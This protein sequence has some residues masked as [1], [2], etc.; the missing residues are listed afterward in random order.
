MRSVRGPVVL[1]I[2]SV[3]AA[4]VAARVGLDDR[5]LWFYD[6]PKSA[7]PTAVFWHEHAS[8]LALPLWIDRLGMGFPVYAEGQ[9][10]SFYLPNLLLYQFGPLTATDISRVLHLAFAGIGAGLIARR[11]TSDW[12]AAVVAAIGAVLAGGIVGKLEWTNVVVAYAWAPWVMLPLMRRPGPSRLGLVGAGT[13]WGIAGLA[14]HPDTWILIGITAAVL[15]LST[16][17]RLSTLPRIIGF[18]LLSVAVASVQLIPTL[19]LWSLSVRTGGLTSWDLFSNSATPLDLLLPGF[20]NAF[21]QSGP[22]GWDLG[23]Q[24]YPGGVWGLHEAGAYLGLPML[25][26]VGLG[27]V[28]RRSRPLLVVAVVM[29]GIA[30][31]G[32]FHPSVWVDTPILNG[33][34]HPTRSY[35]IAG[36]VCSILAGVGVSRVGRAAMSLRPAVV[37]VVGSI[38]L[39]LLV[40]YVSLA[41]P[42]L[43]GQL[44]GWA[45]GTPADSVASL[46]EAAVR[47]LTRLDPLVVELGTGV[48]ALVLLWIAAGRSRLRGR[49]KLGLSQVR[50]ALVVLAA[51]PLLAFSPGVNLDLT[52]DQISQADQPYMQT[53][54]RFTPKRVVAFI[55]PSWYEGIPNQLASAGISELSMWSSL[56]LERT[57]ALVNDIRYPQPDPT[58][59]RAAGVDVMATFGGAPCP[60]SNT[61]ELHNDGASVCRLESAP[62]PP[63]WLPA[64]AV[65]DASDGAAPFGGR[66]IMALMGGAPIDRS[67]DP[68]RAVSEARSVTVASWDETG[69]ELLVDA[70]DA[71]WLYIDRAWWPAWQVTVDGQSVEPQR[72]LGGQLVPVP[73][74]TSVVR[75]SLVPVDIW[76]GLALGLVALVIA[77]CW[78]RRSPGSSAELAFEPFSSE[79]PVEPGERDG[80]SGT[81]AGPGPVDR[82]ADLDGLARSETGVRGPAPPEPPDDH[83]IDHPIDR[84]EAAFGIDPLRLRGVAG[85]MLGLA[86][87]MTLTW[88]F[89]PV[90]ALLV[91]PVLFAVPGWIIVSRVAPT[92]PA[93]GRVGIAVVTSVYLSAHLV[94]IV[95]RL[96]GF[97]QPAV[98]AS[99]A[100]LVQGTVVLAR[101]RYRHLA[102]LRTPSARGIWVALRR[103]AGAWVVGAVV[104]LT[105]LVILG[106][107]AWTRT[108]Q[109][110]VSG[111]WNWSDFLVHVS[112]GASIL[113]G[114]F[115]PEVPYFAGVPLTYH[116]FA[117]FHGAIAASV[118]GMDVIPVFIGTSALFAAVLALVVWALAL[119]LTGRRRVATIATVLVCFGGG[120]GWLRLVGELLAGAGDIVGLVTTNSYDNSWA[121]GWPFFRIASI[122]GT[123]FFPHRATTLGLPGLVSVVLLVVSCLGRR[124]AGVLLAGVLASLLAPFHFY[125]FPA[126]YLIV[127]LYVL[128]TG[129][130][131]APTVV[132]DAA[133]FLAPI[134]LAI[135]FIAPAVFQQGTQ[136]AFRIVQGWSE[137][138]ISDG[139]LA[140]A[141]FYLTNLGLPFVLAL[142]GG[143]R[144]GRRGA[145]AFLVAWLIA[146]FIVPNVMVLS[147]VEFDMN[148]F[149]QI[150][151]IAVAI[152]AATLVARWPRPVVVAILAFSAISPA[153]IGV[154]HLRNE[155]VTLTLAQEAAGRWIEQNTPERAVFVTDTFI[156]SPVDLAGR[157]R[158]ST[159]GPYVANLGY[160]P[161]QRGN[162]VHAI[163]CDGADEAVA[164]MARYG[165]RYVLS[166]GGALDCGG[167]E[168]TDFS[169]SPRFETVYDRDGVEVWWLAD[170]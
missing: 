25:A 66:A 7:Y 21:I 74:G 98:L 119:R 123:G 30:V 73:A 102:P 46:R 24:W 29:I 84:V 38:A 110:W 117:D 103:D 78:V 141:F 139:P 75:Q 5:W 40:T 6:V 27:A 90:G 13:A 44:V 39:Y 104:G 15:M 124:P 166:S 101:I 32:A 79:T 85:F 162:D 130:W 35:M 47:A 122:F 155:A 158:I 170:P 76:F 3:V 121:D 2:V 48:A 31:V 152:L 161:D 89:P 68:E 1:I 55:D 95:A 153:L 22:S 9:I 60:G 136:G 92:V 169:K 134:V 106:A 147:S 109:G 69:A 42:D 41:R 149:F 151:W 108:E 53:V 97:G 143:I 37:L 159:F 56:N 45:F 26:L 20:A 114:N 113:H 91:W 86:L 61:V 125:A 150:M 83:P 99:A 71:G 93:P 157:L 167:G 132:R 133:L 142:I 23:T 80:P 43:F 115:P 107:N 49:I 118:A 34:R 4:I 88:L 65:G 11:M 52:F 120:M 59:A 28:A 36:L 105:V 96:D 81:V 54:A 146:L 163:Y 94:N 17:P 10:G 82:P 72:A 164:L 19:L 58:L 156:N 77:L 64:D 168:P 100:L 129:R 16:A 135:P 33:L 70:P 51:I 144:V 165:A 140:V 160:N 57:D 63:Y 112:I 127:L 126:T 12:L 8:Q 154:W 111:G 87:A 137:A 145:G 18:A 128:T 62:A 131:Q 67:V 116:W 14:S 138:P 50:V 148:K